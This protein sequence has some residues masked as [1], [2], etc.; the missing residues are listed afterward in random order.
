VVGVGAGI[1]LLVLAENDARQVQDLPAGTTWT[2]SASDT[3]SAARRDQV[4]GIVALSLGVVA[5]GAGA[6]VW[7]TS[8]PSGAEPRVGVTPMPGGARVVVAF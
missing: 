5:G 8:R 7:L 3:Y 1:V 4:A 2:G 6:L